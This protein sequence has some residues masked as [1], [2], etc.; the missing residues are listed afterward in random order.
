VQKS[1]CFVLY[2]TRE[3]KAGEDITV[4]YDRNW[5]D[6]MPETTCKCATCQSAMP[7]SQLDPAPTSEL[8]SGLG[9]TSTDIKTSSKRQRN[10]RGGRRGDKRRRVGKDWKQ[11]EE[12]DG[13][14]GT[15][16]EDVESEE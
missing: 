6:Y 4:L 7:A 10:H 5:E 3:I 1:Y 12:A 2:T 13:G 9:T 16:S 14:D 11:A 15:V 8:T